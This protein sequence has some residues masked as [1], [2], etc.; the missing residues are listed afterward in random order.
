MQNNW[1][2]VFRDLRTRQGVPDANGSPSEAES[3]SRR[4][5][6]KM[7]ELA[8]RSGVPAATIKH[9]IREELLEG[10][11]LRTSPNMAYYDAALVPRI[12]TIKQLQRSQYLPLKVIKTFLETQESV[13]LE[14]VT[15]QEAE[16]PQQSPTE[17]TFAEIVGAGFSRDELEDLEKR[18]L[19]HPVGQ[20]DGRKYV[21]SDVELLEVLI[22]ASDFGFSASVCPIQLV[23]LYVDALRPLVL[24]ELHLFRQGLQMD[25]TEE[26]DRLTNT[27]AEISELLVTNLRRRLIMPALTQ[28]LGEKS[29]SEENDSS[30]S[31]SYTSFSSL[32]SR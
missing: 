7:S 1:N 18:Q 5:L 21:G 28:L 26:L 27:A 16:A 17:L 10:P 32:L 31:L 3:A 25:S 15:A 6:I 14:C 22:R 4:E 8:K 19:V 24:F 20:G 23:K 11:A 29:D 2:R 30:P 9:Y 13:E 12:K